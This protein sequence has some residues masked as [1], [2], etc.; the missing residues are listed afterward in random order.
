M[1]GEGFSSS[2]PTSLSLF[3]LPAHQGCP[4]AW[5]SFLC[6][7]CPPLFQQRDEM[8]KPCVPC[9]FPLQALAGESTG[10]ACHLPRM[11]W[12]ALTAH[13]VWIRG[14]AAVELEKGMA[15]TGLWVLS[16]SLLRAQKAASVS[17]KA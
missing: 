16:S 4:L 15:P 9:C 10:T 2:L 14:L 17:P 1:A 7:A 6:L 12:D 5:A 8:D 13:P 11:P 3:L